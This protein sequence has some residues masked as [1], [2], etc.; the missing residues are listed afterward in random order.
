MSETT[1]PAKTV[2]YSCVKC[3]GSGRV[4]FK[5]IEDGKC[6]GCDGAGRVTSEALPLRAAKPVTKDSAVELRNF[7]RAAKS[8]GRYGWVAMTESENGELGYDFV[9]NV[10]HHLGRVDPAT[11]A[12]ALAAFLA[13]PCSAF[14][15]ARL[16][17]V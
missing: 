6:F 5:H 10:T 2:T 4:R 16:E 9:A 17:A 14:V 1:R 8:Q 12:K 3:G 13:L 7:Y 11:R 15:R